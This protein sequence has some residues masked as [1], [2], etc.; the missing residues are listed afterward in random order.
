MVARLSYQR[1]AARRSAKEFSF[2]VL[3]AL[4]I[5]G[6]A[7]GTAAIAAE[8][9]KPFRTLCRSIIRFRATSH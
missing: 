5:Q 8:T 2:A 9:G 7:A 1:I 4:S 3:F 6:N